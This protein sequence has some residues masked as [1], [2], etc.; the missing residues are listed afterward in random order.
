MTVY[1]SYREQPIESN[2]VLDSTFIVDEQRHTVTFRELAKR[3]RRESTPRI[4]GRWPERKNKR[5][6]GAE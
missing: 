4:W 2:D 3:Y 6:R 5:R 1:L